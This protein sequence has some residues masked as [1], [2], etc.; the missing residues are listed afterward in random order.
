MSHKILQSNPHRRFNPLS[1]K[2]VLVSPQRTNRPWKGKVEKEKLHQEPSYD[3][4]CYLCPGNKRA[5]GLINEK[6]QDVFVFNNDFAAIEENGTTINVQDGLF[7]AEAVSGNCKVICYSPDHSK[8]MP[9]LDIDSIRKVIDA[10]CAIY[11]DLEQKY[12]WVQIF[13]N[14]GEI[15]GC[16]N[17]HP[18]GQ[19]WA[20]SFIPDE[21]AREDREQ[22]AYFET[23]KSPLLLDYVKQEIKLSERI[24]CMNDDWVALVPY[25][26]SWPFETLLLPRTAISHMTDLEDEKKKSLARILKELTTRYDNLFNCAFP[27]S[28]GW[29]CRPANGQRSEHWIMHAH[30]YPPLLRSATIQKFMV[31]YELMAEAQRDISPEQAAKML[32][33]AS[34]IHYKLRGE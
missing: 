31:G 28:M 16:S 26:A 22:K 7:Q 24:V 8:T 10:W 18:H 19:V 32:Q 6:Y 2:W 29:H 15:N 21:A 13:E 25:W 30:F 11:D 5:S 14:K 1:N 33:D 23:H 12:P 4:D 34:D 3:H 20:G 17:P 9:E 27:Y